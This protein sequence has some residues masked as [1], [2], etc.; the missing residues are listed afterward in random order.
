MVNVLADR[1]TILQ[2]ILRIETEI[3]N[4]RRDPRYN[5]IKRSLDSL[6]ERRFRSSTVS[7]ASPEDPEKTL[8]LRHNSQEMKDTIS[9]YSDQRTEYD[10]Q[11]G[12]LFARK[13]SLE[14]RLFNKPS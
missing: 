9:T 10:D 6:K 11:I 2:E 8:N 7:I 3:R 4:V 5:R 13:V 14:N 1:K 12:E